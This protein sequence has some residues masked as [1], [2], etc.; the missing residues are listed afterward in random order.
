M[1]GLL[2]TLIT[3]ISGIVLAVLTY[4]LGR[5]TDVA[6]ARFEKG[7]PLAETIS[8]RLIELH[9]LE[10]QLTR[11]FEGNFGHLPIEQGAD[12]FDRDRGGLYSDESEQIDHLYE[13]R[14]DLSTAVKEA[15]IYLNPTDLDRIE[16]YLA[17]GDFK[18]SSAPPF[19]SSFTQEF[20]RNLLNTTNRRHRE[21]LYLK[22]K[23]RLNRMH[24]IRRWF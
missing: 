12:Y 7:W 18:W 8:V 2:P 20:F 23:R 5:K 17:I 3:A 9:R 22:I 14:R 21:K 6:K 11:W 19:F 15:R 16:E 1:E 24:Q 10:T 4:L 13:K